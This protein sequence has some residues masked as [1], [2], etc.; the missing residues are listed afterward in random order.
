MLHATQGVS[1][2]AVIL[3]A[4]TNEFSSGLVI[5]VVSLAGSLH[6][7]VHESYSAAGNSPE[8]IH[9]ESCESISLMNGLTNMEDGFFS[10]R[11][12]ANER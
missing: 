12:A 6:I 5:E 8:L 9:S 10:F 2:I 1:L 11:Q 4:I 7:G 3:C